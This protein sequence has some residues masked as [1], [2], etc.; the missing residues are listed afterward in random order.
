MLSA[1][2]Q[3]HQRFGSDES[4]FGRRELDEGF[5][6]GTDIVRSRVGRD[7]KAGRF[8]SGTELGGVGCTASFAENVNAT[9]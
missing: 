3:N 4:G 7:E 5:S 6:G 2:P 1:A 9:P 8:C